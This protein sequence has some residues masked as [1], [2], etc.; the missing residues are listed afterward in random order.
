MKQ[1]REKFENTSGNLFFFS[2]QLR[3]TFV[4]KTI[5]IIIRSLSLFFNWFNSFVLIKIMPICHNVSRNYMEVLE[6]FFVHC[7]CNFMLPNSVLFQLT[8]PS[9][10]KNGELNWFFD[11]NVFNFSCRRMLSLSQIKTTVNV[12]FS[13]FFIIKITWRSYSCPK[14]QRF[15]VYT[16]IPKN[17]WQWHMIPHKSA[18]FW[19]L[20]E[21]FMLRRTFLKLSIFKND[22]PW[23]IELV[24][25]IVCY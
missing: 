5:L 17:D 11:C 20:I 7:F 1:L 25:P 18:L 19:V 4:L 22:R 14:M 13:L 9:N 24:K 10:C 12:C 2:S 3:E 15:Y 23:H 16:Y 21:D 8:G 6:Q